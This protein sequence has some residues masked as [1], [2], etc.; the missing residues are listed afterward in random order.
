MKL[1]V[2]VLQQSEGTP[3]GSTLEWLNFRAHDYIFCQLHRGENLPNVDDIDMAIIL[4]GPMNVDDVDQHPWLATEKTWLREAIANGKVC[5][6]LCL[7][8]QL[9]AQVTGGQVRNHTLWEVGW[10]PVNFND[11]KTLTVFQFHQDTFDL[12]QGARL[13]ASNSITTHQA[14]AIGDRTVGLQFHPEATEVW[15]KECSEETPYPLGPH[16][17]TPRQL[18]DGI[19]YIAPMKVWYFELLDQLA[20]I[21]TSPTKR[22]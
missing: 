15:V 10:H 22:R 13:F 6:G 9:I 19:N 2:A 20:A 21:A 5:L 3:P 1:K 11:G 16:A 12:P 4:G 14:F 17:Q 7:G 8:A 18:L